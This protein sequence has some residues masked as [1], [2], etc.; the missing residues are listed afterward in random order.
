LKVPGN[1]EADKA[2]KEG[3]SLPPPLDATCTLAS[4]K[5]IAKE[6]L[7]KAVGQLWITI[8]P[9]NYKEL[10]IGHST[11][12]TLLTLNRH[13]LGRILAARSHHGDFAD[14]HDRFNH[15]D[16]GLYC[17]CRKRKSPLHFYFCR[18]GRGTKTLS[19]W[20]PARAIP[21]L[22]GTTEGA[23]RLAEWLTTTRFYQDV[24]LHYS[25]SDP[26]ESNT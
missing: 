21:W 7:K 17:S 26:E 3:A 10:C 15:A 6:D 16:A 12:T 18:I 1:E 5:R 11:N 19:K 9:N 20:P 13:A 24:C 2:A 14:Y 25:T 8:A 4:L 23:K 22:L